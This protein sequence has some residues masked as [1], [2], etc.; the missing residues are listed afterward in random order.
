MINLFSKS[1]KEWQDL[2]GRNKNR[3]PKDYLHT[4]L[5]CC[6]IPVY[7]VCSVVFIN[8]SANYDISCKDSRSQE[9]LSEYLF[10]LFDLYQAQQF[11]WR[12]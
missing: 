12:F 8:K 10:Q 11:G 2:A 6:L 1:L 5:N 9:A 7:S 4:C 3:I